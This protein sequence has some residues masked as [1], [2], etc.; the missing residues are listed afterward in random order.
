MDQLRRLTPASLPAAHARLREQRTAFTTG[1]VFGA[2]LW[3]GVRDYREFL[4]LGPGGV[5]YN[6]LGWAAITLLIRPFA[7]SKAAATR[8]AD[9]PPAAGAH[10]D[11]AALPPRAGPRA[12]V[13]GIAPHRQLSQHPPES[14][15]E[16]IHN[17]FANAAAQNPGLLETKTSL[18]ERH[19]D[20]LFVSDQ[21]LG[22]AEAVG[23]PHTATAS[24]GE[25]GHPHP[26]L[27]IHL[28]VSPADA[29]VLIEKGWAERH[30]MSVPAN[31]WSKAIPI[32]RRIGDTFLM[33]YG[34]RNEEEMVVL[35]TI[36][37]NS[38][39]FMTGR[40]DCQLPEWKTRVNG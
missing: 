16:S 11:V 36:L 24:R 22:N 38:I 29:R 18:Y 1:V 12:R 35:Q 17:L 34:P 21:L 27:S 37:Q 28:Y 2:L 3:W 23:L 5:P 7:L 32:F 33:V 31:S 25:I 4:A 8:T 30:R 9:Y 39:R 10:A 13:G 6:V 15:R 19:N 20:A 40:E 26:D 14:M